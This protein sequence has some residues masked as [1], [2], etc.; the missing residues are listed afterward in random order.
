LLE[1]ILAKEQ[2]R[3]LGKVAIGT[4]EGDLHDI[5]KNLVIIMMKGVGFEVIDLGIDQSPERFVSVV[6]EN[7]VQILGLSALLT[8]TMPKLKKTIDALKAAGVR[9][10]VKVMVGG[11]PVTQKYADEIGADS[12]ASDAGEAAEKAKTLVG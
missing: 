7:D 6:K 2:M 1:P 5:G 12:F 3:Y 11:A 9:E 8:T 4:V 10:K